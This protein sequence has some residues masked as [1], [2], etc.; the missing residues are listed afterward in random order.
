[1]ICHSIEWERWCEQRGEY[2]DD[3]EEAEMME[4]IEAITKEQDDANRIG[5]ERLACRRERR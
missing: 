2:A 4:Y 3:Y 5:S 1:M